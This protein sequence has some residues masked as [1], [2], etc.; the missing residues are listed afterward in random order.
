MRQPVQWRRCKYSSNGIRC[1]SCS[2][3][4]RMGAVPFCAEHR[5]EL[6]AFPGKDGGW[7]RFFKSAGANPLKQREDRGPGQLPLTVAEDLSSPN[8][9]IEHQDRTSQKRKGWL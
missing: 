9:F 6:S 1:L 3:S 2:K 8:P 4:S 7:K 5:R